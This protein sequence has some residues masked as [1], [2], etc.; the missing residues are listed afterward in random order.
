MV[1]MAMVHAEKMI[2]ALAIIEWMANLLGRLLTAQ[3][4]HAQ[5]IKLGLD[6]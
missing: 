4:E 6:L 5:R 2:N 1:A 3:E